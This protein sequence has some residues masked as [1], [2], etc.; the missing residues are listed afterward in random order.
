MPI[1]QKNEETTVRLSAKEITYETLKKWIVEGTLYPGEKLSDSDMADYF[2]VSRTP[3]REAFQLLE[4]QKLIKS[5][6]GKATIVTEV[7]TKNIEQW[8]HPLMALQKLAAELATEKSTSEHIKTL[9]DINSNFLQAVESKDIYQISYGD[10]EF[11]DYIMEITENSY[12]L[13]FCDILMNHIQRLE[14]IFFKENTNIIESV[15]EHEK[16][17][18]AMERKDAFNASLLI[19]QHWNRTVMQL[20]NIMKDKNI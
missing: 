18:N 3:I 15:T 14:F 16:I 20:K 10:K 6:P 9:K 17:I 11:H 19:Q 13:D 12:I 2:S 7:E 4:E 1:P 8:Y 5:F